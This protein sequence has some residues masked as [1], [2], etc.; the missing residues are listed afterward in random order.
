MSRV[1]SSPFHLLVIQSD[2]SDWD[3]LLRGAIDGPP[4]GGAALLRH[5]A[6][7]P[8]TFRDAAGK[9][10]RLVVVQCA[11]ADLEVGPANNWATPRCL[12]CPCTVSKVYID[13]GVPTPLAEPLSFFPDMAVIRNEV[14]SALYDF[15]NKL[16]AL[17]YARIPS[18]NN[19]RSILLNADRASMM[20]ALADVADTTTPRM[21]LVPQQ[22]CADYHRA[23]YDRVF[24]A[25]IK[26]GSA[27]AGF[28]KALMPDRRAFDDMRSILPMTKAENCF[29][30]PFLKVTHDLRLQ[31]IGRENYRAFRRESKSHDWKTNTGWSEVVEIPVEPR[32]S[33]W[34]DAAQGMFGPAATMDILTIDVLVTNE[35][36]APCEYV[37]EVNGTSSGFFHDGLDDRVVAS[38]V[39]QRL[40]EC[41][42]ERDA[43]CER[44]EATDAERLAA[45]AGAVAARRA[46]SQTTDFASA[47]LSAKGA[48]RTVDGKV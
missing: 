4:G 17:M 24:P 25:V 42:A 47:L 3:G 22:F 43:Q 38:I 35:D 19:L 45:Q 34:L 44:L 12:R 15:R 41:V 8:M 14:S 7:S 30:E 6:R 11:W 40:L 21:R 2:G 48:L 28:G 33:A 29:V 16:L 37:L 32:F 20:S 13:D 31:K 46:A 18:L 36:G 23:S 9:S 5:S 10:R 39:L 1:A 27:H 26:F